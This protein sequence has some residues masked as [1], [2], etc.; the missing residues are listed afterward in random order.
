MLLME[1]NR[2]F[3]YLVK[4][5]KK[6]SGNHQEDSRKVQLALEILFLTKHGK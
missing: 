2:C 5:S 6:V 4:T 3:S 1:R